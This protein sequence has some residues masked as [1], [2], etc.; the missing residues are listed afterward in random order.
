[1]PQAGGA[2]PPPRPQVR[3]ITPIKHPNVNSYGR[4]CHPILDRQWRPDSS[5][6]LVLDCVYGLL[7]HPDYDAA[8]ESNNA[9]EA[10]TN[11]AAY[12]TAVRQHVDE[13]AKK[14]TR[15]QLRKEYEG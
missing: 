11:R 4:I 6:R 15:E 7:L 8:M 1:M 3:F 9:L 13:H 2:I 5:A 12:E 14:K 10:R